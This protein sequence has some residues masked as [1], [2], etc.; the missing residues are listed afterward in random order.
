MDLSVITASADAYYIATEEDLQL[1]PKQRHQMVALPASSPLGARLATI[2]RTGVLNVRA[3]A[4]GDL[5]A[6]LLLRAL[7]SSW[8]CQSPL[9]YTP[10]MLHI[11]VVAQA[12]S[13]LAVALLPQALPPI[14]R[15]QWWA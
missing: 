9:P 14:W 6:A 3:L 15:C 8:R 12:R 4:P 11:L 2:A 5:A 10:D 1:F 7:P 13:N